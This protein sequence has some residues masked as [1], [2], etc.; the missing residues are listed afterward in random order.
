MIPSMFRKAMVGD[1]STLNLDFT[2]MTAT[3]DLTARGL[4]FTRGSTGTRI[5]ASGFVETM[6]NNVA[7]F[8]HDPTTLAP[9]GLLIEGSATNLVTQSNGATS[10]WTIGGN[11]TP[12]N[13]TTDLVSPDG[14]N[15]AT[16]IVCGAAP[17]YAAFGA[18]IS[19]LTGG[20][21]YTVSYWIRGPVG[22][23]PRLYAVNGT[24]GDVTAT[25]TTGTY[26]NTGWTRLTQTYTLPA[27][28]TQVYVYFLS[29]N[30]ITTGDTFYVYGFQL[31]T[32]SGASSLIP[33]GA[34]QATRNR[35]ELTLTNLSSIAFSQTSGTAFAHVEVREKATGTFIPYGSFDTSGGGR[36]WWWLR[37]NRDVSGGTRLLGNVFNSGGSTAITTSNY[38]YNSGNGGLVK[39]ATSLDTAASSLVYVIGGGS[40]QTTTASA[41]TLATAAQW[42]VNVNG[43]VGATDLGSM[44]M[45]SFK[46]WPTNL[47]NATLQSLTT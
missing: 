25:S 8:D 10:V 37:H 17:N 31:E 15:N 45:R 47:P 41:F 21:T 4:T 35:D 7:R 32:G 19:G 16:K 33:T 9:R 1:G 40:P 2:T 39:F 36:C 38:Q 44:W 5:N 6:S 14:T 42:S 30:I 27:A 23:S 24:A 3:A 29:T 20:A 12:T 26:N 43:D 28:T 18:Q 34:S 22:H 46:Y 13:N 11:R